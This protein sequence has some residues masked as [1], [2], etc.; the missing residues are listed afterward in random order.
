MDL[1]TRED[2]R[3]TFA[4][5]YNADPKWSPDGKSIMFTRRVNGVEQIHVMDQ[6]GENV[7]TI[8][9]GR[10]F[11]EQAEWAPDGRQIVFASNRTG[12]YK[13]YI[14]S[15]DGSNLR[16][17]TRTPKGFEENSPTWTSRRLVR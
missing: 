8:T 11:A 9:S 16:R 2:I 10:F 15:T 13:L 6:Y 1:D 3:L 17:L 14:V 7:R 4:G 12:E 5:F